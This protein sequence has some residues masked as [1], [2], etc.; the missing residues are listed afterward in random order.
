MKRHRFQA[1]SAHRTFHVFILMCLLSTGI[2]A[3]ETY[4][5]ISTGT[6]RPITPTNGDPISASTGAFFQD[7]ALFDLGGPMDLGFTLHYRP[8]LWNHFPTDRMQRLDAGF[9]V[10]T[11]NHTIELIDMTRVNSDARSVCILFGDHDEILTY[12]P[13][14]NQFKA[15]GAVP[16]Q[17]ILDGTDYYCI[18]DPLKELVY[19]F[20]KVPDA[21]FDLNGFNSNWWG[22]IE[23]I[24]DRNGNTLRYTYT[25]EVSPR[26]KSVTDGLGRSIEFAY[27]GEWMPL[28]SITDSY[29]RTVE[30]TSAGNSFSSMT[31]PMGLTTQFVM[32]QDNHSQLIEQII[33]PQGNSHIDQTWTSTPRGD[34][35]FGV[36][37]QYDPYGNQ[38]TLTYSPDVN[39]ARVTFTYP[40]GSTSLLPTAHERYPLGLTDSNDNQATLDYD[41]YMHPTLLT[42]RL[43]DTTSFSYHASSGKLAEMTNAEGYVLRH[44]YTSQTQTFVNPVTD[45]AVTFTF[46]NRSR[47]DYPDGTYETSDY[48]TQGN[49]IRFTDQSG[50][51]FTTSYNSQGLPV[52]MTNPLQGVTTLTYNSDGTLASRTDTD[53]GMTTYDYD[54]FKRLIIVTP[55]DANSITFAYNAVDQTTCMTDENGHSHTYEYDTNGN[56]I[57]VTDPDGQTT[58]YAYDLLDRLSEITNRTDQTNQMTYTF[59]NKLASTTNANGIQTIFTYNS[60]RWLESI[61]LNHKTQHFTQDN[62]GVLTSTTSPLGYRTNTET[63]KLG[64]TTSITQPGG[65]TTQ[66]DRD[67]M[68]RITTVTDPLDRKTHYA[69]DNNGH[70]TEV[71]Q[72]DGALA[73]Y[74][75]NA[76]GNLTDINDLNG[77]HWQVSYTPMGQQ[78]SIADP[79]LRTRE[80]TQ[81]ARTRTQSVIYPD[82]ITETRTYDPANNLTRRLFSDGTD[83]AF[84]YDPQDNLVST[85]DLTVTRDAEERI[86]SSTYNNRTFGV[87]YDAGGR[88]ATATYGTDL[89]VTYAYN[90]DNLVC[91]IRD[92]LGNQ[93]DLQYDDNGQTTQ[94]LRSNGIHTTF[95][96]NS[97]GRLTHLQDVGV[98]DLEY[99]YDAAGQITGTSG[100]RPLEPADLLMDTQDMFSV[101]AASQTSTPG[102]SYDERG[103]VTQ[104]PGH[105]LQW[106]AA[107]RLT[108][109]DDI[110]YTYNGQNEIVSRTEQSNVTH[111]Y[112]NHALPL[113]PIVAEQNGDAFA[114]YY[115]YTPFGQ[116]LYS[117]NPQHDHAVAFYHYDNNGSTLALTNGNGV[118]TDAYAYSPF[119]QL[120]GHTGNS[121]QPFTFVGTLGVRQEGSLYHMRRRYYD[122][123][124]A[125][126]LSFDPIWPIIEKPMQLNPYQYAGCN[127]ITNIDPQGTSFWSDLWTGITHPITTVS[128]AFAPSEKEAEFRAQ[129]TT[130]GKATE[131]S[132]AWNLQL[133]QLNLSIEQHK[134]DLL[135]DMAVS[136]DPQAFF[137]ASTEWSRMNDMQ[138]GIKDFGDYKGGARAV[139]NENILNQQVAALA[140]T[141]ISLISNG[142]TAG[143]VKTV[144]ALKEELLGMTKDAAKDKVKEWL[145]DKVGDQF[146]NQS[147][148][149]TDDKLILIGDPWGT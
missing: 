51:S 24:M 74:Q 136:G 79:L 22:R 62:E 121:D 104:L 100:T 97:N 134:F 71:T 68:M 26:L 89:T 129:L 149:E 126:F 132:D 75:Y 67:P 18:A 60:R 73:A 124:T 137:D 16:Y 131:G 59:D 120:L 41:T 45:Q 122:P 145:R 27:E 31:D 143:G 112:H 54:S 47:T 10:F 69:Y 105:T 20:K 103:R 77:Q 46:Y 9:G 17:L 82:G 148:R 15:T 87:T 98:I 144:K 49:R 11:C 3:S 101:D 58:H 102:Y 128:G 90:A 123:V 127:P 109:L 108:R 117:I 147:Q 65:E 5:D 8:E 23:T 63:N 40:D 72:F 43:G 118:I 111:Y 85:N 36:D 52:S 44:T 140:S 66:Y 35:Y 80:Y 33:K 113:H 61:S 133:A 95:T 138:Q 135:L 13:D 14:S 38:T 34:W 93:I 4:F 114:R 96:W 119:G 86:T 146:Q 21:F 39:D 7:W 141:V 125:K 30:F 56:L 32:G 142:L 6:I 1:H 12:D 130:V 110:Q 57:A 48:D 29:G 28:K 92:T 115:V 53:T 78:T 50:H 107:E 116:L 94:L 37:T 64:L 2:Q 106:D 139:A 55:P 84:A 83:I 81:G 25:N 91:Q 70:L 76:L 42:D 99:T 88:I 19:F